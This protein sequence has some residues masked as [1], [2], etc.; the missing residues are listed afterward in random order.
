MPVLTPAIALDK[1]TS[2]GDLLKY[3]RRR[4]GLTQQ[5]LSIAVNYSDTQ[6]SRLE[7]NQRL[8]DLATIA[9]RFVPALGLDHEPAAVERLVEL[10]AA[11]RREDA[12]APGLPPFKGL[13]FFDEADAHLFFGRE[14]LVARLV[15]RLTT[16]PPGAPA[17]GEG[18]F[19]A[20]VGA[21]G[22][23]K[24]SIVR[25]GLIPA[26]RWSR[27]SADW[28]IHVITPTARPL[29]S[30]AASLTRDAHSPAATAVLMDD[31]ARD[32]R[33]FHLFVRKQLGTGAGERGSKRESS[34][35][36]SP[37]PHLILVVD[38]FEELFPLCRDE[39]ERKAFVD[40]LLTAV[41]MDGRTVVV[42]TLRA[43]F[44]AHCAPYDNLREAL[45]KHQEYIGPMNADELR[46]AIEEPA[47]RGGW[48]LELELVDL[49]LQDIGDEPGALP[50]LSHALL[51]TWRRRQ[52][53]RLTLGGYLSSGGVRGAIAE[54]AEAVFKDQLS[55]DQRAIAR[56]IF[57]RLT[58][59]GEDNTVADT[60]RRA[61]FDELISKPED[62]PAVQEVLN[63][64]ADARLIVTETD[65]AEVAHE[66]LI[67]EWPT[68]R[69]W[70]EENRESLR[71]HRRLTEAAHA[72]VEAD[73]QPG[74][75]YREARL[76]QALEWQAI[77]EAELSILEREFLLASQRQAEHD[78]AEREA[79]RQ[80]ELEAA[81]QVAQAARKLA[82]AERQRADEQS[83][84]AAQLR[85]RAL[86]LTGAFVV[87]IIMAGAALFFGEQ[88]R[89]SAIA[90]QNAA[91]VNRVRELSVEALSNLDVDPELSILL[92]LQA[93]STTYSID[94]TVLPEAEDALH[95]A[96]GASHV[97][98][99]LPGHSTVLTR[100]AFSPDGTRLAT[101]D[102]LGVSKVL[103]T[104]TGQEL[105]VLPVKNDLAM[106]IAFSPNGARVTTLDSSDEGG[107]SIKTWEVASG[108][109]VLTIPLPVNIKDIAWSALSP[110][111][112]RLV[113]AMTDNSVKV[114]DTATGQALFTL[115]GHIFPVADVAFSPDGTR[116]VTGGEDSTAKV[117][118]AATGQ[119][120][121]TLSGHTARLRGVA[122]SPDGTRIAT[123]GDDSTI[124]L[125]DTATGQELRTLFGHTNSVEAVRFSPDGKRLATASWDRKVIMWDAD[126][127]QQLFTLSGHTNFVLDL[128]FSPDGT[129][130]AT[131]ST[132]GTVKI[133]DASSG[134]ELPTLSFG[135]FYGVAFN[136]E[137]T[138]IAIRRPNWTI[139]IRDMATGKLLLTLSDPLGVSRPAFSPDG[140]RLVTV[141]PGTEAM[142]VWDAAT[143]GQLL[144]LTD[145]NSGE[146]TF[147]PNGTR[148]VTP[149]GDGAVKVWEAATGKLLLTLSKHEAPVWVAAY[150]LDESRIVSLT[151]DGTIKV[152]DAATGQEL[153]SLLHSTTGIPKGLAFSPDGKRFVTGSQDGTAKVWDLETGE[154]LFALSGH[155]STVYRIAF[156]PDGTQI[157]TASS[158]ATAKVWEAATGK[159]LLTLYGP[160]QELWGVT[161]SLDGKRLITTSSDGAMRTYLLRLEDLVALAKTRLTRTWR[162]EECQQYLHVEV[163]PAP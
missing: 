123:S 112:G 89:Q 102:G 80:R 29:E 51:E 73:R 44:Y 17:T 88:A 58:E 99:T 82:E 38:Q 134:G 56:R 46:Q 124:K 105:L 14:A 12:P 87:A 113:T 125:W 148:I 50:L 65:A 15:E 126:T 100:L 132:D 40:N 159:L 19:L 3:F 153:L 129:R 77:H 53:H 90:A 135:T 127:G 55:P 131:S 71:L 69:A 107:V 5:E 6:I 74:D 142:I 52:G 117:W 78:A 111:G 72:W 79:Q 156:S 39:V 21:S 47:K 63:R 36:R 10:A 152:W 31:F 151:Y 59:L 26:L 42:P 110:D 114:W 128:A 103:D 76:A 30:L 16:P 94:Q 20:I 115:I 140:A 83:R 43:D 122:F 66:A 62:A 68:L 143:G 2:F 11:V 154:L 119:L 108:Q 106:D 13:Q 145:L 35:P 98:L 49:I 91:R 9:A 75:L 163:C 33:S 161:F 116:I 92:A 1:F 41:E 121:L 64:L 85:R 60:R 120:L 95:R 109:Q 57:L 48:E 37:D 138:R 84:A 149:H 93:V 54:T 144:R 162:P 67:R 97:Q 101:S 32:A 61:P 133:W 157:A 96:V 146:A 18:R 24:S 150:N 23:G 139:E 86:Y 28:P 130:L 136:P 7:L 158:D 8:P 70:L 45:A 81:K 4:A 104:A 27:L 25:A 147:S 34:S 141:S 155:I 118:D 160:T 22:S 137:R